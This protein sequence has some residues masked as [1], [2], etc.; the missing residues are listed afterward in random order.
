MAEILSQNEI[1]E[2]LNALNSGELDALQMNSEAED[3][4]I[5]SYDFRRPD[6]FA[7]DQLRTM[8]VIYENYSRLIA[9]YLSGILR[10]F[11]QVDVT[12]VEP[13]TYYEFINSLP[14]PAVLGIFRFRPLA[15][16]AI[17]EVSP[18]ITYA[19]IDK[20][21]GGTG[22]LVDLRRDFTDIELSLIQR[23][24][25]E[26]VSIMNEP[27]V[28]VMG[29]NFRLERIET[30]PQFA[31]IISPNETIAIITMNISIGE[32]DGLLNVC[33][34]FMVIEPIIDQLSTKY[35]FT[36]SLEGERSDAQS[37]LLA[38]Q[39]KDSDVDLTAKLGYS[40]ITIRE[41]IGLQTGDVIK[42]DTRTS[43]GV[44]LVI[45]EREKFLGVIGTKNNNYAV[46]I[47][48][49]KGGRLRNG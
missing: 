1:D 25:T 18:D 34:P 32:I 6:K 15:G 4:K 38:R 20:M 23:I 16:S 9:S 5:K 27:W 47:T 13:Q 10:S 14:D 45:G 11:C 30:N 39:I 48:G 46:K 7:K 44:S 19:I 28:N 8:Q 42:L 17:I 3:R 36:S 31:Q 33:I 21:L 12:S 2:L 49:I 37:E 35:W 40:K 29:S 22:E 26:L 43:D 24:I 41:F